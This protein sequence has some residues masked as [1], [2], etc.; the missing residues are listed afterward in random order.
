MSDPNPQ[1]S[2]VEAAME[3]RLGKNVVYSDR[4][5]TP[6]PVEE[7]A[8]ET[9]TTPESVVYEYL[10]SYF[11]ADLNESIDDITEEQLEEAVESINILCAAVNEYFGIEENMYLAP[12]GKG[13]KAAKGLYGK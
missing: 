2:L 5:D 7:V 3:V 4:N 13:K 12:K 11:G 10:S 1:R 9:E 6:A 8:E